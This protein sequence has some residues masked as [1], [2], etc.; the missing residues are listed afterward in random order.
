MLNLDISEIC[1]EAMDHVRISTYTFAKD[2]LSQFAAIASFKYFRC[3]IC[4]QDGIFCRNLFVHPSILRH[5]SPLI[6]IESRDSY[7]QSP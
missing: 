3:I 1:D 4:R 6:V 7:D 2:V 5:I